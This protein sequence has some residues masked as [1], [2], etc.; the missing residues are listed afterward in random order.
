M[1]KVQENLSKAQKLDNNP[2]AIK[3]EFSNNSFKWLTEHS[4]DFLASGYI[5]EGTGT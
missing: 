1:N 3:K 5:P 2:I 4:R